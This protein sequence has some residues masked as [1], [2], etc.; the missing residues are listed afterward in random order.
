MNRQTLEDSFLAVSAPFLAVS[1]PIQPGTSLVVSA[2]IFT[3][4]YS[5]EQIIGIGKLWRTRSWRGVAW[6][7]GCIDADFRESVLV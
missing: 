6:I 7:P 1:K 2:P 5:L 3:G 4:Q